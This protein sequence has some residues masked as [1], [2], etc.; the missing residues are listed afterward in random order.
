M[1]KKLIL[2]VTI[3]LLSLLSVFLILNLEERKVYSYNS[4]ALKKIDLK[5]PV[6]K[7]TIDQYIGFQTNNFPDNLFYN[8]GN[9]IIS[10]T[11]NGLINYQKTE[12]CIFTYNSAGELINKSFINDNNIEYGYSNFT[13]LPNSYYKG[14]G[15]YYHQIDKSQTYVDTNIL[16][17]RGTKDKYYNGK[18]PVSR[19]I[20]R[21]FVIDNKGDVLEQFGR[22]IQFGYFKYKYDTLGR[23]LY[24]YEGYQGYTMDSIVFTHTKDTIYNRFVMKKLDK[25]GNWQH[26]YD[27]ENEKLILNRE[28]HY[29]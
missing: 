6:Q 14:D 28:I 5:G 16:F 25:Y 13:Y 17:E 9:R 19:G 3:S 29:Y 20:S 24:K 2:I 8:S 12:N 26:L 10:F 15:P 11:S 21:T 1:K 4:Y 23:L 18:D 27:I 22:D 7:V